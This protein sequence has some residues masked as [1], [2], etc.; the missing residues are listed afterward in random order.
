VSSFFIEK[1]AK[2][3]LTFG[4]SISIIKIQT[5]TYELVCDL[6]HAQMVLESFGQQNT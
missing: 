4:R 3:G 1:K 6:H 2:G 5:G